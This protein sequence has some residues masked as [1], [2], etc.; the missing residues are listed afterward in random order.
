M[1]SARNVV[2]RL[3]YHW[4]WISQ[5]L[6]L[7]LILIGC[8]SIGVEI[9]IRIDSQLNPMRFGEWVGFKGAQISWKVYCL[10]FLY[11]QMDF[12]CFLY[13][14]IIICLPIDV[15]VSQ[16]HGISQ[17]GHCVRK[18]KKLFAAEQWEKAIATR[19]FCVCLQWWLL[20][21]NEQWGITPPLSTLLSQTIAHTFIYYSSI[22]SSYKKWI[23]WWTAEWV[24]IQ[25]YTC[26][27][28]IMNFSILFFFRFTVFH[29]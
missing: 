11:C 19:C 15:S 8:T 12:S 20:E 14:K 23:D 5:M 28:Y 9:N 10:Q 17:S 26:I 2:H 18:R 4:I 29:V 7:V 25:T 16:Y 13:D 27:L 1:Q 6:T 24:D 22:E 21:W 3:V